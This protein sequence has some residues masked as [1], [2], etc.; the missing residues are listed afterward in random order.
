VAESIAA[1]LRR[2]K[3]QVE[4]YNIKDAQPPNPIGYD[5]F[6]IGS[7]VYCY[8]L[9]FNIT[10]YLNSLSD[11]GGLPTYTFILHGT[12]PFDT[13]RSMRRILARKGAQEV[14]H[15][16][17]YGADFYL[18]YLKEGYLFSPDHPMPEELSKAETFGKG[19]AN[20]AVDKSC[21]WIDVDQA[22][23]LVYRLERFLLN[24]WFVEHVYS[25]LF[26]VNKKSCNVCGLCMK[27][28]PCANIDQD[29]DGYPIWGRKCL[30]C[31][32]CELRCPQDAITSTVSWPIIRPF[33]F[34]NVRQASRDS[35]VD[36]VRVIHS[37]GRTRRI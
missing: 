17:C 3:C 10:D 1:G 11:L 13:S 35:S 7:P 32:M 26:S 4:L 20:N 23:T 18:P 25:R 31:Q 8:R 22:P 15:F 29:K 19:I 37:K 9:P 5:I 34:Y 27:T 6:G 14:G 30:L 2:E 24:R 33:I 21:S 12:Y 36:H 16:R 28:C